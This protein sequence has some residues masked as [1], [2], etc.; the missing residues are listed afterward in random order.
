MNVIAASKSRTAS[1]AAGLRDADAATLVLRVRNAVGGVIESLPTPG[2]QPLAAPPPGSGLKPAMGEPG[3]PFVGQVFGFLTDPIGQARTGY[4]LYGTV[5]WG[6]GPG[7]RVVRVLGPE[8]IGTVLANRD[9]AFSNEEGWNFFIG[10]FFHRGVML[11]DFDE[12]HRHRRI[13]QNAFKRERLT[14]YLDTM[15][16]AIARGIDGWRPGQIRL[17]RAAKQLTLDI[18]TEVFMGHRLG[19]E[20]DRINRAFVDVVVGGQGSSAPTC[21]S[22]VGVGAAQPRWLED[23]FRRQIP[24]KRAGTGDDLFSV[25]CHAESDDGE[26]FSDDD[27]VN[28]MIFPMMAAHDTSTITAAMMGWYLARHPDW[29]ERVRSECLASARTRSASTT[30]TRSPPWTSCSRRRCA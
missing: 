1:V 29:Q 13:M 23:Y 22:G 9:R 11:I 20:A 15:N 19:P 21:R 16:P 25:L 24:A 12:H 8:G 28:H 5:A 30:S 18:A 2:P 7:G 6:G 10:P 27:V 26:R 3:L 17:Y 4:Q 14:A